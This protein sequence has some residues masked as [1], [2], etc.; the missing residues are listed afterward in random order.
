MITP[1]LLNAGIALVLISAGVQAGG[2][3]GSIMVMAGV[4]CAIV[5]ITDI[6]DIKERN[7]K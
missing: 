6:L 3:A 4:V 5:A 2:E 7:K 1:H